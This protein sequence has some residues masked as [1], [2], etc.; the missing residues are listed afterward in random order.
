MERS[1]RNAVETIIFESVCGKVLW[2]GKNKQSVHYVEG[3]DD[4]DSETEDTEYF[5]LR[6]NDWNEECKQE[7]HTRRND[8]KRSS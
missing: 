3:I 8:D 6:I 7:G 4:S 1:A 2:M 5:I